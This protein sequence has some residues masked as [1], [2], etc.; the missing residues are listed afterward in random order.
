M[1]SGATRT[2]RPNR[3]LALALGGFVGVGR[4]PS[5]GVG[6]WAV[7]ALRRLSRVQIVAQDRLLG[8]L[9][10]VGHGRVLRIGVGRD[11]GYK[12]GPS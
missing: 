4:S 5:V 6:T 8:G 10:G 2:P 11:G 9:A 3:G 12:D 1:P 7:G